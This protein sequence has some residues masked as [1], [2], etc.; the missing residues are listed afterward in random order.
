MI[1]NIFHSALFKT[2]TRCGYRGTQLFIWLA[3]AAFHAIII[4]SAQAQ[5]PSNLSQDTV[6]QNK[7]LSLVEE[8]E[9]YLETK[10]Y[11]RATLRAQRALDISQKNNYVFGEA[12]SVNKLANINREQKNYLESVRYSLWAI[13]TY[14]RSGDQPNRVRKYLEIGHLYYELKAYTKAVDYF[15]T[16]QKAREKLIGKA[17]L[18][19]EVIEAISRCYVQLHE[20]NE[21]QRYYTMLLQRYQAV[22]NTIEIVKTYQSLAFIA[23][24][25]ND[26]RTA[27]DYENALLRIY[28]QQEAVVEVVH[29]YNNLGFLYKRLDDLKTSL[30]YFS[31]AVDLSQSPLLNLSENSQVALFTNL[32]IAYTNLSLFTRAKEYYLRALRIRERQKDQIG[33][34][35]VHNHLASNYFVGG[36][37]AQAL[38]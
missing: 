19:T 6:Y 16:Y 36:K 28:Q 12:E 13:R 17:D 26:Y 32:G 1:K 31:K 5:E 25:K 34:A 35:N 7:V 33:E 10:D 2:Q 27:I 37:N 22:G 29:A 4:R 8:S 18:P 30:E 21:A 20:H 14:E 38:T 23:K 11:R 15:L 24:E 9:A 3:V